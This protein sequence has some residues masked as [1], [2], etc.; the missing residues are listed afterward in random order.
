VN[1]GLAKIT[2]GAP[3]FNCFDSQNSRTEFFMGCEKRILD[4][5][6]KIYDAAGNPRAWDTFLSSF[7]E[8]GSG[9]MSALILHD[10]KSR[11]YDYLS[12]QGMPQEYVDLWVR[13]YADVD[14]WFKGGAGLLRTG[15][16]GTSQML[17]PDEKLIKSEF[18][19]DF[20]R[21]FDVFNQCGGIIRRAGSSCSAI[22][23]LRSKHKGPFGDSEV[24]LLRVFM[25]HLQ[26]V[27][28]LHQKFVDLHAENSS[29]EAALNSFAVG[30]ILLDGLGG[31]VFANP[32]A[33]SLLDA[34]GGLCCYNGKLGASLSTE[35]ARLQEIVATAVGRGRAKAPPQGGAILISRQNL[36]PLSIIV[37]PLP[38][39]SN[40]LSDAADAV[41]F[42]SDPERTIKFPG[43][44]LQGCYGLTPAECRVALLLADGRPPRE[45]SELVGV[46][47]NT[48]KTHLSNIYSKTGTSG[49]S[50]LVRLLTQLAIQLPQKN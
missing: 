42:V 40:G 38:D 31:L 33:R 15:W 7:L 25:P 34:K 50:A 1:R 24:A 3:S 36:R 20:L 4:L 30:V 18:Y 46:S 28:Q 45:I 13:H 37:A 27:L 9:T 47:P 17:C 12:T 35:S 16:V 43:D 5:V 2:S 22:T 48:L 11:R 26:R 32:V 14:E 49:Q 41:V 44:L 6:G 21:S 8:L 10:S 39:H 23:M 29:L 19:S